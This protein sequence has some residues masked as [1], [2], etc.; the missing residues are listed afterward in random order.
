MHLNWSNPTLHQIHRNSASTPFSS[1]DV[2]IS[3][4]YANTW[5]LVV[6]ESTI[7]A[8]HPVHLHGHDFYLVAQGSGS[9]QPGPE[10]EIKY[11][12]GT[13]PKRDTA[14]L[15]ASG[16]LVLAFRTDNPGAWLLHCH[17]GW[18]LG[19]ALQFVEREA[20]VR[21]LLDSTWSAESDSLE[22][23]CVAWTRYCEGCE[24]LESGS[25]V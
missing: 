7:N 5:V 3:I 22:E 17:I 19:F 2:A 16:H 10:G 6:I 15:P 8:P 11:A 24:T 13:I 21:S 1:Q 14:L 4:P 25:G 23:N 20:E 9:Y 18:H 12:A